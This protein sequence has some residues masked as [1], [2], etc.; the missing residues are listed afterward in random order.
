MDLF[1]VMM[2][3]IR[4]TREEDEEIGTDLAFI[5]LGYLFK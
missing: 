2:V 1:T 3:D 4:V 5:V